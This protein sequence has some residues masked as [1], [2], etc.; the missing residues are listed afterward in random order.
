MAAAV[1][2]STLNDNPEER[3]ADPGFREELLLQAAEKRLSLFQETRARKREIIMLDLMAYGESRHIAVIEAQSELDD[4]QAYL[5]LDV[6][7]LRES[8][9]RQ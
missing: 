5:T 1:W 4:E 6:Q 9:R 8:T 7:E 2:L 3:P